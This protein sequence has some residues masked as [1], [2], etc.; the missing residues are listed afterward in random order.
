MLLIMI[1]MPTGY[2]MLGALP[3]ASALLFLFLFYL[4]RGYATPMLRDLTNQ[5]CSSEIRATVL[6]IRSLLVRTSFS[7]FGPLIGTIAGRISLG[8]ALM[9]FGTILFAAFLWAGTFLLRVHQLS[10]NSPSGD[11]PV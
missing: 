5:N 9:L 6:S 2:I 1:V 7:L 10:N 4:V 8:A 3:V 11:Q